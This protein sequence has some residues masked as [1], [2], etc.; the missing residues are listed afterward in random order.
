MAR[1]GTTGPAASV[2]VAKATGAKY[3]MAI[4]RSGHRFAGIAISYGAKYFDARRQTDPV[5]DGF[6]AA[7]KQF[8]AWNQDGT[9]DRDVWAGQG[10]STYAD[11]AQG[12]HA[13]A[14]SCFYYSGSWQVAEVRQHV[15]DVFDWEVVGVALRASQA[16]APACRAAPVSS[17]SNRPSTPRRLASFINFLA[18]TDITPNL[19]ANSQHPGQRGSRGKGCGRM[20]VPRLRPRR[21]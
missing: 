19:D 20:S 21:R 18:Q 17:A 8:V 13:T 3:A 9:M 12:V 11:A 15:G 5:D 16:S 2:K 1:P 14:S 6:T 4:D 7:A 10:G